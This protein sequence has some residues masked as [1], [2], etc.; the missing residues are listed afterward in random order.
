MVRGR[1]KRARKRKES[2]Q[3]RDRKKLV[4]G[5]QNIFDELG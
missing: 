5:N 3:E 1:E 2:G 4:K